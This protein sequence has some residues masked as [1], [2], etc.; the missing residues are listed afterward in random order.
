MVRKKTKPQKIS[1][2]T[3]AVLYARV[4]SKDQEREG[5]SIPAQQKLLRNHAQDNEISIIHEFQ[6]V[7][8]AKEAGRPG[9]KE[10]VKFLKRSRSCKAI[11]VEKTDRLYRNWSDWVTVD[12]LGLDLHFVKEGEIISPDSSSNSKLIH[13]IKVAM[14]K[15][16]SD[17]L[18][19]EVKKG[20][21]EK[22]EQ[23]LYPNPAPTGYLNVERS[24]GKKVIEPDKEMAPIVTKLFELYASGQYSLSDITKIAAEEGLVTPRSKR[25]PGKATIHRILSNRTYTGD[26]DFKGKIYHGIH[27]PLVTSG[28][29]E[30]VQDVMGNRFVQNPGKTKYDFAFSRL[31]TCGHCGCLLVAEKKKGK[32]IYYHCTGYKTRCPEP[33]VREEVLVKKFDEVVKRINLDKA[34]RRIMVDALSQSHEDTRKYHQEAHARLQRDYSRLQNRFDRAYEDKLDGKI[35]SSFFDKKTS[36][37]NAEQTSILRKMEEHQKAKMNYLEEGVN[38]LELASKAHHIYVKRNPAEKRLFL[39]FLLSNSSWKDGELEVTFRKPFDI[40]EEITAE[41]KKKK[42]AR[43]DSSSL[44]PVMRGGRDSNP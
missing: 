9:F 36:E 4:S 10:M 43:N 44:C 29:W 16:Y 15:H 17:N 27:K 42:A 7:E 30:T 35:T 33:Y 19:E 11:L 3:E 23:G 2:K 6:D 8:T 1:Q 14:A 32:Y 34:T 41:Q 21:L 38:L 31:I 37:W 25:P 13:S 12:E 20:L 22:A 40:L 5:Y 39:D 18:S 26:F 28:L 24:D